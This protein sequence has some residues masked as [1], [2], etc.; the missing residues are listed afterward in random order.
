MSTTT[1]TSSHAR[2]P[3]GGGE[4][5]HVLG[6]L[7][8]VK[9]TAQQ[10]GGAFSMFEIVVPP[11]GGPPLHRHAPCEAFHVLDGTLIILGA[12]GSRD[13]GRAG[14]HRRRR[15]QRA[16]QLPQ[17]R[18]RRRALPHH[19]GAR[20]LRDV[21]RRARRARGRR[22]R[23]RAAHRA[24][25]PRARARGHPPSRHRDARRPAARLSVVR[26]DAA[27]FLPGPRPA[28]RSSR[29]AVGRPSG[30]TRTAPRVD[31]NPARGRLCQ[32]RRMTTKGK[33]SRLLLP[34]LFIGAFMYILDV[35][36]V[37]VTARRCTPSSGIGSDVQWVVGGY[38][39]IFAVA[40]ISG[41]RL[42]DILGRRR[43]FRA[44]LIGF[45]LASALCAAR[46]APA[47]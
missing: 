6:D 15:G 19:A 21:L 46:P 20:R 22:H 47:R 14:R 25:G 23:A 17:P 37:Y 18:P 10:T 12:D 26:H 7:V 35:F 9:V 42:G 27:W 4:A 45:T 8:H 41:G 31:E 11:G 36:I 2:V 43:M 5:L 29:M 32:Y 1:P 30:R 3:A 16:A 40:L 39:L 44:G 34:V 24:T 38:V 33:H 13:A 28:P